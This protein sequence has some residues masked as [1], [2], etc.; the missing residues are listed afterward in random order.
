[1]VLNRELLLV[2]GAG[3]ENREML[4]R[5][6]FSVDVLPDWVEPFDD[7][8]EKPPLLPLEN[9]ELKLFRPL[10]LLCEPPEF[11][12][13][14]KPELLLP[15]PKLNF[16]WASTSSAELKEQATAANSV[17]LMRLFMA[18]SLGFESEANRSLFPK[19]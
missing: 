3:G 19:V 13:P 8:F 16:R 9:R 5:S 2:A 17:N 14:P 10:P 15:L 7:P 11:R 6:R 4:F 18:F 12:L 1:M